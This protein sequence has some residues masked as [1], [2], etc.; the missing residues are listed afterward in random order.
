[1]ARGRGGGGG[2]GARGTY[3]GYVQGIKGPVSRRG[4][5]EQERWGSSMPGMGSGWPELE[6]HTFA[7]AEYAKL[8]IFRFIIKYR[9]KRWIEA[10][11]LLSLSINRSSSHNSRLM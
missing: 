9:R 11:A 3:W 7:Y 2:S 6:A 8:N 5:W 1:M 4:S 10:G